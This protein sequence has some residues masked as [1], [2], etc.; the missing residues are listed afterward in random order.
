MLQQAD[1]RSKPHETAESTPFEISKG[2][3]AAAAA[4]QAVEYAV[5][6]CLCI[7]ARQCMLLSKSLMVNPLSHA[8][9]V[10]LT[11]LLGARIS[12]SFTNTLPVQPAAA[13]L[14][15]QLLTKLWRCDMAQVLTCP[16]TLESHA[17]TPAHG[18]MPGCPPSWT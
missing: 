4:V 8:G 3:A 14:Q 11:D 7:P 16:E 2:E 1:W 9:I 18:G 17:G 12:Q 6:D 13:A 15:Q 10:Q 5:D